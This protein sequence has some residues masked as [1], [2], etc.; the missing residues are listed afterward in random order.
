MNAR[1]TV[2]RILYRVFYEHGFASLLL[3][4]CKADPAQMGYITECVYGTIRNRSKMEMYW[5]PHVHTKVRRKSEVLLDFAC[6]EIHEMSTPV[7]AVINEANRIADFRDRSFVN[8]VLRR[9]AETRLPDNLPL[10]VQYSMPEWIVRMWTKQYGEE[11]T[12]AFLTR[13]V[14]AGS[15]FGRWNPLKGEKEQLK[16]YADDHFIDEFSFTSSV[17]VQKTEDFR[18]GRVLIQNPSSLVPVTLLNPQPGM[19]VLD[20]CASPGTKTQMCAVM[21]HN[22][23]EITACD[24]YE[25]RVGLI[26][27]LMEKTGVAIVRTMVNDACVYREEWKEKYDRILCDVPCS[28]LGDLCHKP[29]IRWHVQPQDLD[30]ITAVQKQILD[31][32]AQYLRE[33]G[34]LVY[35]T[36]TLNKKENEKQVEAFLKEHPSFVLEREMTIFPD[37]SHDGFYAALLCKTGGNMI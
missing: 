35:S 18:Q 22:Q 6:Y 19:K 21:M 13:F 12:H 15:V 5:K 10:P 17:P 31:V 32:S 34:K 24:L 33:N 26:D 28:G 11:N 29:E 25:H 30:E 7:Y 16:A 27:A 23:G 14:S 20:V 9:A 3:R 36:C 8:A 37:K 2:V 4:E 1:E